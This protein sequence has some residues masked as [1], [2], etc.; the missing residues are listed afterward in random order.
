M[1]AAVRLLPQGGTL[2]SGLALQPTAE[3]DW[4]ILPRGER[5]WGTLHLQALLGTVQLQRAP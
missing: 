3:L 1:M 2:A 4:T 5:P